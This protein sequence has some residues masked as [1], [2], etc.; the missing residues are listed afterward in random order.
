MTTSE[1]AKLLGISRGTVSRVLNNHPNVKEETRQK[2]LTAIAEHN[3]I[4]NEVARSLVM[5][6]SFKIAVI[7]FSEPSF[8]WN[9]VKC[10]VCAAQAELSPHGVT[11]DYFVTDILSPEEQCRL[12]RELPEQGYHAIAIAPNIPHLLIDELDRLSNSK[13]PIA[14]FNVDIPTVNRLCYIGCDYT[15]AGVLAAELIAKS[16]PLGGSIAVLALKDQILP[17][18]QRVTG[19]RDEISKHPNLTICHISRFNRKGDGVCEEVDRLLKSF[20]DLAG[21]FVSF[22]ALKQTACAVETSKKSGK[23]SVIGYDL[24]DEIYSHIKKG[25]ITATI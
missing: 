2:V 5:K 3:Y 12:L 23:I 13:F 15:Q 7:V 16:T 14:L 1:I 17:I 25:N 11:V 24:S 22:G 21:I 18:E 20:P 19:F 8:F 4:P 10:G 6:N 9:Q